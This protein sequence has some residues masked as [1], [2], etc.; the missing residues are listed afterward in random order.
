MA[1]MDELKRKTKDAIDAVADASKE[2]Y[3]LA[4]EKTKDAIDAITDVSKEAYKLAEGKT[5][6]L[7]KRAKIN[8]EIAREKSQI[9]RLRSEL[10]KLYYE[11]H[12]ENPIRELAPVCE[13]MAA[14]YAR[15]KAKRQELEDFIKSCEF[16]DPFEDE[17]ADDEAADEDDT[18]T[19]EDDV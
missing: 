19:D 1:N 18:H 3:K 13:E 5:V 14:A 16:E 15:I 17:T 12:K 11:L 6:A 7:A 10:G 8:S 9:R 2:A 4:E